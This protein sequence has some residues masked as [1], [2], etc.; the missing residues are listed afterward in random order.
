[1][2]A[3]YAGDSMLPPVTT[4]GAF[5]LSRQS[6]LMPLQLGIK[7]LRIRLS[8]NACIALCG[9]HSDLPAITVNAY[10]TA[11]ILYYRCLHLVADD[12][13]PFAGVLLY[14]G[15]DG[16]T[17]RVRVAS[18]PAERR[19]SHFRDIQLAIPNPYVIRDRERR[20]TTT[21][22][23][24]SRSSLTLLE[25]CL[26]CIRLIFQ[27]VSKLVSDRKRYEGWKIA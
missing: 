24:E 6:S 7:T 3:L 25:E 8:D 10:S 11:G 23:M 18:P 19:I 4:V 15:F 13:I 2:L 5:L 17:I 26:P 1:M 21:S 12:S 14:R 16:Y 9:D 22:G 20:R 27:C